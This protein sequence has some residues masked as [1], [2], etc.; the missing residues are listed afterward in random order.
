[1]HMSTVGNKYGPSIVAGVAKFSVHS[2]IYVMDSRKATDREA[3]D[4]TLAAAM[5]DLATLAVSNVVI[6]SCD[7]DKEDRRLIQNTIPD[8]P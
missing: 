4:T 3:R 7:Q 8:P 6:E 1:M 2:T 5:R